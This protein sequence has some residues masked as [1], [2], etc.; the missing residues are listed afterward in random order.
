MNSIVTS[1]MNSDEVIRRMVGPVVV[2]M[3]HNEHSRYLTSTEPAGERRIIVREEYLAVRSTWHRASYAP[4]PIDLREL[5]STAQ[6][7][8][9]PL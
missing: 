9:D 8:P 6:S 5:S 4:I 2:L 3:M 1:L 7:Q